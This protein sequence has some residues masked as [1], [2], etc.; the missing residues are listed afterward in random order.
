MQ[1]S[2]RRPGRAPG[3]SRRCRRPPPARRRRRAARRAPGARRHCARSGSRRVERQ[4]VDDPAQRRCR[5]A[6]PPAGRPGTRTPRRWSPS[7][8][9][10]APRSATAPRG[11]TPCATAPPAASA[12]RAGHP[13]RSRRGTMSPPGVRASR[14]AATG[15]GPGPEVAG[16]DQPGG[17]LHRPVLGGQPR[18]ERGDA[19][20]QEAE[21][22][23]HVAHRLVELGL[24]ALGRPLGP[25]PRRSAAG[26]GVPAAR[27]RRGS[28]LDAHPTA[29]RRPDG[30]GRSGH[31]DA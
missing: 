18:L 16:R 25:G 5:R 8:R 26:R 24:L 29:P 17:A 9:V 15:L 28:V 22:L 4:A 11:S 20:R 1:R 3:A 14:C 19:G 12:L 21:G 6:S 7:S 10:R 27:R 23:D 31:R 30:T 13:R 2:A